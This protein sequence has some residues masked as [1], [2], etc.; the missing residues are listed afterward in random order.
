MRLGARRSTRGAQ[1]LG[2]VSSCLP[3]EA[4]ALR[5]SRSPFGALRSTPIHDTE[6]ARVQGGF[7]DDKFGRVCPIATD[8]LN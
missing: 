3:P 1:S 7:C 5:D 6:D 2:A 4:C 8:P